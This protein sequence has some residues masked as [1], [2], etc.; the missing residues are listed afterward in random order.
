M[1]P[2]EQEQKNSSLIEDAI[3]VINVYGGGR[4]RKLERL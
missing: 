3:F 4:L 1:L 2:V